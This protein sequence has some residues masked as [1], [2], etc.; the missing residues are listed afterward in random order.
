MIDRIVTKI[1]EANIAYRT[2][3]AVISDKEYDGL[4][5]LLFSYDPENELFSKVGLEVI[6]ESRKSKLPIDMASMNKIK[7]MEEIH[8]WIRLKGINTNTE[9]VATPKF[10]GLSLCQDEINTGTWTRGD[11]IYGQK[12]DEHYKLIQ[13]HLSLD[14][15]IFSYTYGEVIMPKKTFLEKYSLDA[16]TGEF[17]NPRN[18]VAG[19]I[20]SKEVTEPLKDCQFIK[21]GAIPNKEQLFNKK[22]D[23]LDKLNEGQ[24]VK[25]NYHVCKVNELTEELLIKLFHNWSTDYEIDGIILE[26]NDIDLQESLG[27]ETSSNNPCYARAFKHDSFEQRAETTILEIENN[28]SKQGLVKPVAIIEPIKLDGVTVSRCTLNNYKFVKDNELGVGARVVIKRS[29]MVIPKIVEVL[30]TVEFVIPTIEG[31]ELG[32]NEAGIELITLTETD[33][34]KLKQIVAFFEILEAD[35]VGEGVITQLWEAGFQTIESVLNLTKNDLESIDRFGKRKATIVFDSIKKATTNVELSK[36]QHATGF[37]K[38]LGSKKLILLDFDQKPTLEQVMSIEGFAEISAKSYLENYDK[39][40]TFVQGLP[41]TIAEKVESVQVG[42]YLNGK[43]FVFTGVRLPDY[44]KFILENGGVISS[45]VSKNTTY[46]VM[47]KKGSGSSKEIKA[48]NLGVVI[49]E[50]NDLEEIIYTIKNK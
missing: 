14:S 21:Y 22:S 48:I 35:N 23:I 29:G 18:L 44:E 7:T 24:E 31:V 40:F 6:D 28:I 8:T 19:L 34:Q 15:N 20:N 45:G 9:I 39:F 33:E 30:E 42:D 4:L 17:A 10:D 47:K 46:L 5:E 25:V 11:G 1:E 12:S 27:R 37:F 43:S 38:G 16:G 50:I 2:G 41:I 49:L 13:N 26:V 32:W 3:D 36:L